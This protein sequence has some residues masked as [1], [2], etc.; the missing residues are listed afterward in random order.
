LRC[1]KEQ[2]VEFEVEMRKKERYA[3]TPDKVV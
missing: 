2:K 1:A 3:R